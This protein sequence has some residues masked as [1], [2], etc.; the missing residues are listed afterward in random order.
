MFIKELRAALEIIFD[1]VRILKR[2]I[3]LKKYWI[4]MAIILVVL[5][6][7]SFYTAPIQHA[8]QVQYINN[9]PKI[10]QRL[11]PEQ[12][13]KMKEYN[14]SKFIPQLLITII[15]TIPLAILFLAVFINW[16]SQLAEIEISY[17]TALTIA[18]YTS[19]IDFLWGS[20]VKNILAIIKG[21]YLSVSTSFTLFAPG[22]TY[23]SKTY[24]ILSS[25][26]FFN[27]WSYVLIA[28][29]ISL[30]PGGTI[31]KGAIIAG[32]IFIMKTII[33]IGFSMIF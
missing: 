19:Y 24:K 23:N 10:M 15:V 16:F 14:P 22:L 17:L 6:A 27:M 25:F 21:S 9:N 13:E 8:D 5:S 20:I 33:V 28:L 32:V 12:I 4:P 18:S 26:D 1:P 11:S 7:F 3:E 31:K 29:G 2:A 30:L